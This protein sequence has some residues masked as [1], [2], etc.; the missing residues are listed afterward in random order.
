MNVEY[1]INKRITPE[2]FIELL[3]SSTLGD[4]RPIDDLECIKGMLD[5]SNLCVS[6]WL[7]NKLIGVARCMT[8][9]NYAC[10]LSDLAV[11]QNY[12]NLGI[13]KSLQK[14]VQS[15]LGP[16]CKLI[17]ISAP[18]A[19]SYYEHIGFKNNTRCWVIERYSEIS[20]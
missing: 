19:N 3:S 14:H 11:S 10:Y 16:R 15:Q 17:L 5:N 9:F 18:N 20:S 13:G 2:Q 7:E 4:R 1:K 6:A 8:D 12:Q